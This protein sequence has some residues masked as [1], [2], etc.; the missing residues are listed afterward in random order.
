MRQ[1]CCDTAQSIHF[2]GSRDHNLFFELTHIVK[3][4]HQAQMYYWANGGIHGTVIFRDA[5][6]HDLHTKMAN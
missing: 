6:G 1:M 4:D 3:S 2:S 5:P